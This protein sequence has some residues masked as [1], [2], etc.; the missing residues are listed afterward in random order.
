LRLIQSSADA[1][2]QQ[3]QNTVESAIKIGQELLAVKEA[4]PHGQ[5]SPWLR[6]EIQVS[7]RTPQNFISVA[8]SFKSANMR[9]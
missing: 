4:L 1:I 2:R 3:M 7:E 8:E 6:G 5:F 9:I